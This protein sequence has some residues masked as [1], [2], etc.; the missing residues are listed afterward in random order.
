MIKRKRRGATTLGKPASDRWKQIG[1]RGFRWLGQFLALAGFVAGCYWAGQKA[2]DPAVLPLRHVHLEGEL[3]HLN[4]VDMQRVVEAY[5]GQNFLILDIDALHTHFA[6]NPWIERVTVR[7]RW[8]DTLEVGFQ[9]RIPFGR[10]G[11]NEMVDIDGERFRPGTI[12]ESGPWPLLSGPDGHER[13]L[14]RV[15]REASV[16]ADQA[17]LRLVRLIQDERRAWRMVF[18]NGLEIWLGK[19]L[20]MGRL[21]R[22]VDIYPQVLSERTDEVAAVD[23]RYTNGFAVRWKATTSSAG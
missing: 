2:L 20:L 17:G 15:Y 1:R 11:E 3:R 16:L 12:P 23:L 5:L 21:R 10:W 4:E 8:P 22:F 13:E 19:E 18:A 14:I 9:E 7:R 6:A